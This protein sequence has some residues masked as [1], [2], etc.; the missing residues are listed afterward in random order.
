VNV[1][2]A[3]TEFLPLPPDYRP[4]E[5]GNITWNLETDNIRYVNLHELVHSSLRTDDTQVGDNVS[6]KEPLPRYVRPLQ[7]FKNAVRLHQSR[8][9]IGLSE[10]FLNTS[11][12]F[13][14]QHATFSILE[15]AQLRQ[16]YA[17]LLNYHTVS[18]DIDLLT[19]VH[20]FLGE[21]VEDP[22]DGYEQYNGPNWDG[23]DAEPITP[24]TLRYARQIMEMLPHSFGGPHIAPGADGSIGFYW[25]A[26][27]GPFRSLCIDVGPG[28]KWRAYWQLRKGSFNNLPS[29]KFDHTTRA[30]V[31]F[32]FE[33][34]S[35]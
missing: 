26:D 23:F 30:N 28:D 34:L 19:F 16:A 12:L 29:R 3:A 5:E 25:S 21:P 27:L 18:T 24:E 32:L 13:S 2:L 7:R 8:T 4:A 15:G 31:A 9:P 10:E 33:V 14:R 17:T 20:P 35:P 22:L 6:V 11:L 1:A